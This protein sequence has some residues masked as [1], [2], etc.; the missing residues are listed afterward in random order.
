MLIFNLHH[1]EP[2][3][4]QTSRKHI[5]LTQIGLRRVIQTL[6]WAGLEIVSLRETLTNSYSK[7]EWGRK[8]IITFDDGYENNFLY[9]APVLEE[10]ACPATIFVLPG[11][12]GGTNEW[13]QGDLP[14]MER[15]R[16][17]TLE[18]MKTLAQ[19][20]YITFGSHGMRHRHF[21]ELH[22]AE[23]RF[24]LEESYAILS[25]ELGDAFLPIFAYPWGE[26][27]ESVLR[28]MQQSSYK[29]AFNVE[30]APW[31]SKTPRFEIPRYSVYYRDGN[32]LV[33]LAKLFRHGLITL[34]WKDR[35][36][37]GGFRKP[38][39]GVSRV[40]PTVARV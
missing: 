30:T 5:T 10:E 6:R 8:A 34:D 21:P 25:K 26:T 39:V 32:P 11:R 17:M 20:D 19:S 1:V 7:Q 12:F 33:F 24:E 38:S 14:E 35:S 3:I 29:S 9:A 37:P 22:E 4:R 16:L 2:E 18:Q 15:D 40:E 23:L 28:F 13:D 27:S 31:E 36:V